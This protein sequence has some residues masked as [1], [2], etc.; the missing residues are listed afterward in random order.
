[1]K[2]EECDGK[3][4]S[5]EGWELPPEIDDPSKVSGEQLRPIRGRSEGGPERA[6]GGI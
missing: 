2:E 4:L 5:Q 3:S 6:H 1:M